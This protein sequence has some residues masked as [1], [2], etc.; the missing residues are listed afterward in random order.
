[1]KRPLVLSLIALVA[2]SLAGCANLTRQSQPARGPISVALA[3]TVN[4]TEQPT[5]SQWAAIVAAVRPAIEAA[6]Y[7]FA[8]NLRTAD[9]ILRI[10]FTPDPLAPETSGRAIALGWRTN[11]N[12][13]A[14]SYT[15]APSS[16]SYVNYGM[17]YQNSFY[18]YYSEH[19]QTWTRSSGDKPASATPRR[20]EDCPPGTDHTPPG[21]F[22][23][24]HSG[25]HGRSSGWRGRS[26]GSSDSG[27]S[28]RSDSSHRSDS[29]SS[30]SNSSSSYS[31][32]SYTGSESSSFSSGSSY[33]PASGASGTYES[34]SSASQ[35]A[36]I[37]R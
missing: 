7:V 1:M 37:E 16:F 35:A 6:G 5:P 25:S 11:P 31:S 28:S 4:G 30:S 22:A 34:S 10:D 15:N 9:R 21:R 12:A 3:V 24:D 26:D 27:R 20:R 17:G 8:T 36:Q 13:V 14:Y 2:L 19:T 32:S 18:D 33:S 29:S 23:G